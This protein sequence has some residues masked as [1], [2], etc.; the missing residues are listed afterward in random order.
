MIAEHHQ[1]IKDLLASVGFY[2]GQVPAEPTFPYR[3]LYLDTGLEQTTRLCS[4]SNKADFRFQVT[5]V[6]L[7][8]Q[9]VAIVADLSRAL[10]VD[11]KPIVAG[12][13]CT[14]IRRETSIPVRPD[15]DVTIPE[16]NLHPVYA[17]DT[18]HFVSF[19]A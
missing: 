13:T 2:D 5:S 17:V 10:L 16:Q 11:V 9:A 8:A 18:Y 1:A 19:A 12:R 7:T 6:A 3:V 4:T 15:R 14:S